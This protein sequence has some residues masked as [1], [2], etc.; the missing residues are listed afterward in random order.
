VERIE[1][2]LLMGVGTIDTDRRKALADSTIDPRGPL[3]RHTRSRWSAAHR[4]HVDLVEIRDRREHASDSII[5]KGSG[6][7]VA[8]VG[9]SRPLGYIRLPR[10]G[11]NT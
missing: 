8:S 6:R 9:G 10:A 5:Q 11:R 3:A 4:D 2:A 7:P 1:A